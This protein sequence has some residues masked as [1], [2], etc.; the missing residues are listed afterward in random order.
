MLYSPGTW[1]VASQRLRNELY[2][3]Y[4]DNYSFKGTYLWKL[5]YWF[6]TRTPKES[7]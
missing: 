1:L 3:C 4:T 2:V 6:D 5:V 7:L